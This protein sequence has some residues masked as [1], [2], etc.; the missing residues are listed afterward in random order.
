MSVSDL[1]SAFENVPKL[2]TDNSGSASKSNSCLSGAPEW[3][4]E[5]Y[6]QNSLRKF[7]KDEKLKITS[8]H[9]RPALGRGENYGGVLS[10]VKA[11]FIKSDGSNQRGHYIVKTSFE[12]DEFARKTMEPYDIFNREM[13]IYEQ[14]LPKLKNLLLEIGDNEQI[15]ADTM[16][17]DYERSALIFEDLNV[18]NFV[19]PDR[20]VGLDM[21][22]ARLVLRKLAKMH[23]T[24]A[25]LNE[26]EDGA[27]ESYDKGMFNRHTDNYAPF[28]LG[29]IE[30][31][32]NRVAQWP[33]YEDYAKKLAALV[34]IYMEL[35]KRVFDVTEGHINVLCHGDL[36]TN[37]VLVKYDSK[38][39]AED[40]IIIDFQYAAWGSPA[41][42]LFYFLNSSLQLDM[43][44]NRHEEL[45][46]YYFDIFSDTLRKLRYKSRIPSLHNFHLQ[47]EEKAFYAFHT[48]SVVFAVQ[49][50]VETEDA[51]FTGL[52]QTNQRSI[53]LKR[54]CYTN[55]RCHTI[56]RELLPI[57]E[58]QGLLDLEQ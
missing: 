36:W 44:L 7:Y 17:V 16:A 38:G 45:I 33:G 27:L 55:P 9:V 40:V 28:F 32:S 41:I 20:L 31:C 24:T 30:A 52:M 22:A 50:N 21:D 49:R 57:Y 14:I 5:C 4:T 48:S 6:L 46:K 25:V 23:A 3:F 10:R 54:A 51:D 8:V 37:N 15:F 26:R 35:G 1:I 18:R 19:M 39:Q 12:S 34:P 13:C 11:D 43:H 56:L 53:N 58:R 29:M 42:D 2:K 47:L